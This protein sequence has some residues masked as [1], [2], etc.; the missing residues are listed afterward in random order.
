VRAYS[1]D[2]RSSVIRAYENRQ[3]SQRQLAHF[4]GVSVSFIQ[5]LLQRYRRTG[6]LAPKPHQGGSRGKI[7]P[8]LGVVDRLQQ[9]WPGAS[10]EDL[11]E[12]L[13]AEVHVTVSPATMCRALRRLKRGQGKRN[14]SRRAMRIKKRPDQT[15]RQKVE[16]LVTSMKSDEQSTGYGESIL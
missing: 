5:N 9:Q 10:L 12:R 3:G 4:F 15:K 13:A 8:Y 1:T 2:F 7:I 16:Q 11:C 14:S 6:S